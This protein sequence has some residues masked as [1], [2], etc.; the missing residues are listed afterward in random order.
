MCAKP[1]ELRLRF[2]NLSSR[3]HVLPCFVVYHVL[4]SCSCSEPTGRHELL[5]HVGGVQW[6]DAPPPYNYVIEDT[7]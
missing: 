5:W 7:F 3:C 4:H 1:T 2:H 6:G